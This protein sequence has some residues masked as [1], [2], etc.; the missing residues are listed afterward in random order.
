VAFG[1]E[2]RVEQFEIN[3]GPEASWKA[4]PYAFQ[5]SNGLTYDGNVLYDVNDDGTN[6]LVFTDGLALAGMSIGANGFAGF[7]PAQVGSWDRANWA[8][9]TDLE[10]DIVEN[11]TVGIA[12]RY[13][14]YDDFGSTVNGKISTRWQM[15][16]NIAFRGSAGTGFRAPT[17]GQ[18]NVTKV[19]TITVNGVLQQRGQIPPDNP[20]AQVFGG[21][22]LKEETAYN[23]GWGMVWDVTDTLNLTIDGYW[24][25]MKD[26]ISQTGTIDIGDEDINDYPRLV[27]QCGTAISV[28]QC[29]QD[30]GVPGAA[31]LSSIS[32]YTNDFGTTTTGVDI[33]GTYVHDWDRW[34]ITNFTAAWNYTKTKVDKAGE[35]VSRERV[36]ELEHYNPRNRGIF[37]INHLLGDFR[38]MVRVSYYDSWVNAADT[39]DD[40]NTIQPDGSVN[41]KDYKLDCTVDFNAPYFDKC[42]GD[43]WIVDAEVGYTLNERYTVTLGAQN[44]LNQ[45]GPKDKDNQDGDIGSGNKYDTSTPFGFDGGL[46]YVRLRAD[47][48]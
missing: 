26:R 24:I 27:D 12:G 23:V 22:A 42:Y 46:W 35:E 15:T 37:T 6:D 18:S 29:L 31:D 45:S 33:V 44:L 13:E 1:G 17:P 47:F 3:Q 41:N 16:P 40:P 2:Y 7:S 25:E 9:Y 14:T 19:S 36:A 11:W 39:S 20:L 4:G 32:F 30:I 34:G 8:F 48:N 43:E 28:P 21:E 5:G 10:A 38:A